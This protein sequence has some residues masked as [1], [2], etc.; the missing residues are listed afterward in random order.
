M[1]AFSSSV[2][3]RHEWEGIKRF[4]CIAFTRCIILPQDEGEEDEMG[5]Q[6]LAARRPY[7]CRSLEWRVTSF[8]SMA[9]RVRPLLFSP[10]IHPVLPCLQAE[11]SVCKA[12]Q[13]LQ[14]D[15][16]KNITLPKLLF[17]HRFDASS[18]FTFS[19]RNERGHV[20]R[21]RRR[22]RGIGFP[23]RPPLQPHSCVSVRLTHFTRQMK[24]RRRASRGVHKLSSK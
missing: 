12:D 5:P 21:E 24:R 13:L 19:E 10:I 18:P 17:V 23:A 15:R 22:G 6:P 8:P 7:Y 9:P 4:S 1:S 2:N 14:L 20:A 3:R 11:S 16:G